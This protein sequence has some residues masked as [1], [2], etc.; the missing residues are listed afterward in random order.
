MGFSTGGSS[1][2][3]T[4]GGGSINDPLTFIG[5]RVSF[6]ERMGG[7]T[8]IDLYSSQDIPSFVTLLNYNGSGTMN[9]SW[10]VVRPGEQ[11]PSQVDLLPEAGLTVLQ[12][13]QR[14]PYTSIGRVSSYMAPTGSSLIQGPD[15]SRL[16]KSIQ[17]TYYIF[18]RLEG[19]GTASMP[20]LRYRILG[21][22]PPAPRATTTASAPIAAQTPTVTIA[23]I[24]TTAPNAGAVLQANG[25]GAAIN[26]AWTWDTSQSTATVTSWRIEVRQQGAQS[27]TKI[28]STTTGTQRQMRGL[29]DAATYGGKSWSW[30]LIGIDNNR[31]VIARSA[32]MFFS[33]VA[34]ATSTNLRLNLD[35]SPIPSDSSPASSIDTLKEDI[36]KAA[37][38][39]P[40]RIIVTPVNG[41]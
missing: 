26:F 22:K 5:A 41:G 19:A 6:G 8:T 21:D 4:A 32:D 1:G 29:L 35:I 33:V 14:R 31:Q 2:S 10:L 3:S 15:V 34:P 16:P 17:G 20:M 28:L 7:L 30:R 38:T 27:V 9:G 40:N 18:L 12:R 39:T 25:I 13:S 23:S 11:I 36:S 37:G 24:N